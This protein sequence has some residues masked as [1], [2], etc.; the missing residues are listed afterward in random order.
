MKASALCKEVLNVVFANELKEELKGKPFS[1]LI[2]ETTDTSTAKLLAV[3]VRHWDTRSCTMMDDLLGL[4]EVASATGES[5]FWADEGRWVSYL[6]FFC[7]LKSKVV[8]W[9][10]RY[11]GRRKKGA[12]KLFFVVYKSACNFSPI[13]PILIF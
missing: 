7:L 5:L 8:K 2:D 11:Y 3:L 4:V 12:G 1:I 10:C 9:V 6:F 13:C